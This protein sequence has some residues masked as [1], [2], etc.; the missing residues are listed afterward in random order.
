[1]DICPSRSRQVSLA[2]CMWLLVAFHPGLVRAA[3]ISLDVVK[4]SCEYLANPLGIDTPQPRF[5]WVLHSERRG[6]MQQAYQVLVASAPDRLAADEGDLWNSGR[7]KSES[8]VNILYQGK[9]LSSQQQCFWKVRVWDD[10]GQVSSWSGPATFE[11]GLLEPADWHGRWIGLGGDE[12]EYVS[13]LLRKELRIE[14]PVK[15]ARIYA[16]GIGWSEFYLNGM[17]VGNNVLDPGATDYDQRI[18]YVTH[19]VT[20]LLHQGRNALGAMLGNGW[21]SE[22]VSRNYGNRPQM[23]LELVVEL[24]DGTVQR[25]TS[26]KSW[27]AS[28]GPVLRNDLFGGEVYDARLEKAGWTAPGYDDAS[29]QAATEMKSPGGRLDAQLIEP[30]QVIRVLKP[31]K[32]TNPKPGIFVYDFGQYFGGWARL[33][34]KGPVGTRVALR[35]SSRIFPDSTNIAKTKESIDHDARQGWITKVDPAPGLV[36]KRHHHGADGA[37]DY[38]VLKGDPAGEVYE[39]RFTFHPVRYVQVEGFP[40]EPTWESVEGCVVHSAIDLNGDFRCSNPLLNQIHRNC[41][42]TF[43]NQMY[44]ITLDC[45]YR[46]HWGWL[47]PASNPSTLFARKFIPRF[48][49]KFLCDAQSAQ[50]PDGVIPDVIPNYPFKNRTTG[51]PAWAGNYPL[52]VWY[53]YRY[54]DDRR[55]LEQHYPSMKRWVEHLTSISKDQL[56]EQG[57][58]GDHM[59][60]GDAPG[61]EQFISTETPSGLLWTGYYY[62]NALILAKAARVLGKADDAD[63]FNR[64][65]AAIRAALNDKWLDTSRQC[66]ATG[67]QTSNIF[68]LALR[69]VPEVNREPVLRNLISDIKE[70]RRGHLRTGNLGTTCIMDALA[71]LGGGETLYHVASSRDYPG[72]G[73]MVDQGATTIWEAWGGVKEGFVGYNTSEDSMPMFA[74]IEEFFYNDLAGI[75]GPDYFGDREFS[76]GFRDIQ[77]RPCVFGDLTSAAAHLR[78]VRGI[79]SVDWKRNKNGVTLKASIP[80]SARAK[81]SIPKLGLDDVVVEESGHSLW[82][83]RALCEG[84]SGVSL[85]MEDSEYVIFETGPGS[86]DFTLRGHRSQ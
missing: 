85:G 39:P 43:T 64:L 6:A 73:Y 31:V 62:N 32:L 48:W 81:I 37:T 52:V 77:I 55:L 13:P 9:L 20:D 19:D 22:P 30:I 50:H 5:T 57:R 24:A 72:W 1:M 46:E 78:T 66:Y 51:D 80:V 79:I 60:P 16:A 18:L 74:S 34:V 44:G 12:N 33:R 8:P 70:N 84:R 47:E 4:T 35:H 76:P 83:N 67:S 56:I 36:D 14:R 29:W 49:T 27:R 10:E 42:W 7:V 11:M 25:V 41:V 86:Y 38:Y 28:T 63:T 75:V 17:R 21:F 71:G 26:D 2:L 3:R 68:A 61:K 65:T 54:Y 23:L 45:L 58:Y 59:L 53:V 69:V 15:R 40:G 82:K